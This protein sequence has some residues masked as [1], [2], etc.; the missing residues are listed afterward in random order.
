MSCPSETSEFYVPNYARRLR[1]AGHVARMGESRNA[2]RVLVGRPRRRWE[3][4]IKMDLRKVG[5]D[6]GDWIN[7]A[8]DRDQWQAYV[9]AAINPGFLK[10]PQLSKR[11]SNLISD[12]NKASRMRQLSQDIKGNLASSFPPSIAYIAG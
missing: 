11:D 9:R 10:S 6:D 4:T 8:Q 5:Y 1:W 7:L 12:T 2:Y 3:D